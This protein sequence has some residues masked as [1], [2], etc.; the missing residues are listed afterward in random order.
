MHNQMLVNRKIQILTVKL[1]FPLKTETE[2]T[3]FDSP[4]NTD[5]AQPPDVHRQAVIAFVRFRHTAA[6]S[7]AI[8]CSDGNFSFL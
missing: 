6:F 1:K 4:A 5:K 7:S 2:K 3:A 8:G